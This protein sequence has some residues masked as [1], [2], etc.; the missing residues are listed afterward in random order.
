MIKELTKT[1]SSEEV[2]V[3]SALEAFTD[4][5]HRNASLNALAVTFFNQFT[6]IS[7][8]V[9]FSQQIFVSLRDKG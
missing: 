4:K 6:G 9:L 3:V 2:K 1:S 5:E 8:V 7:V